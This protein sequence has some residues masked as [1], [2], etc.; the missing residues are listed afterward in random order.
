MN[1]LFSTCE[2]LLRKWRRRRKRPRKQAGAS[3]RPREERR[4]AAAADA[5]AGGVS[6][7]LRGPIMTRRGCRVSRR[8]VGGLKVRSP[9]LH[10]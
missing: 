7:R 2:A 1:K 3:G 8:L 5:V 4:E 10:V 6:G 9:C